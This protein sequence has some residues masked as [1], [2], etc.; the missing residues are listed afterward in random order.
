MQR[1]TVGIFYEKIVYGQIIDK[2]F[3]DENPKL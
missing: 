3:C 2:N 1:I